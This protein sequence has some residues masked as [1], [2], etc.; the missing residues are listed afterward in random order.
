[1]KTIKMILAVSV[2]IFMASCGA[3]YRMVTTLDSN[4]NAYREIYARGDSTF[5]AGNNSNNP[6]LFDLSPDWNINR[7]DTAFSYDF[8]GDTKNFNVKISKKANF[9][10]DYSKNIRCNAG[11]RSLAVP[12]ESLVKKTGWFYI[13]YS[14]KTVYK[15]IQ[16]EVPIP[17]DN[18]LNKE[19]QILWTQ[20][21]L[22]NYKV[23][24][25]TEMNDYLNEISD[26]FMKWYGHNLFEFSIG[27]I[28]KLTENQDL[29]KDKD[30]IYK[31]WSKSVK[32]DTVNID[33]KT[34]CNILDSFYK[35]AYFSNL[36]N[37]N[38]EILDK[39][40]NQQ[41]SLV[42]IDSIL[43]NEISYELVIPGEIL[44]T[45][46]PVLHSDTL[47]WKVDGMR[48]LFNDYSLKAEYRVINKWSF[49]LTG[50]LLIISVGSV[51]SLLKRRK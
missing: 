37:A 23:M 39:D 45:N 44:Q 35:T 49:L 9:I 10:E 2:S 51:I 20:G 31:K 25:G 40:F 42:N 16:Y 4:G 48:L 7:Y 33:P 29:D 6:F 24:N 30:N 26:K 13:N 5:M 3:Q 14:L 19:E 8:F 47:V 21:D 43:G 50:L 22:C 11:V 27:S 38:H 36:Y 17:I 18:Y 1:M 46:A 41:T 15:K 34:V 32:L 12:E 28:K